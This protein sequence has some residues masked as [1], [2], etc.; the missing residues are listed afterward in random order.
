MLH[1]LI[2]GHVFDEA[3]GNFRS[4]SHNSSSACEPTCT[5][6]S[7]LH[8]AHERLIPRQQGSSGTEGVAYSAGPRTLLWHLAIRS[9]TAVISRHGGGPRCIMAG[10]PVS[11]EKLSFVS[12]W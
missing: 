8:A 5:S 4:R 11:D 12:S 1:I 7:T 2:I 10:P 3:S 6:R 9:C